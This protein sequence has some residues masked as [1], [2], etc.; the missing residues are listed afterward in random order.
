[1]IAAPELPSPSDG[2]GLRRLKE[3]GI[4]AGLRYQKPHKLVERSFDVTARRIAED[5]ASARRL[6]CSVQ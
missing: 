6:L 4:Y 3:V 2:D 1:M 5:F